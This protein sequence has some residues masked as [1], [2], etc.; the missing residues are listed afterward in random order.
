[1]QYSTLIMLSSFHWFKKKLFGALSAHGFISPEWMR[2]SVQQTPIQIVIY[3]V[4]HSP[5]RIVKMEYNN[6]GVPHRNNFRQRLLWCRNGGRPGPGGEGALRSPTWHWGCAAASGAPVLVAKQPLQRSTHRRECVVVWIPAARRHAN[7]HH[8]AARF[9][10]FFTGFVLSLVPDVR[11]EAKGNLLWQRCKPAPT[12][13]WDLSNK[14][15]I[16]VKEE[17]DKWQMCNKSVGKSDDPDARHTLSRDFNLVMNDRFPNLLTA[18]V[19]QE[20]CQITNK[21]VSYVQL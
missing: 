7:S 18:A 13:G 16:E 21:I 3:A 17:G 10:F 5:G 14:Y 6:F 1:M 4:F 2:H 20:N 9:L 19:C 11:P 8:V 15:F 12:L